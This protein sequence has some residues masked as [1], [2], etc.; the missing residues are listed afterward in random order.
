MMARIA[1][2]LILLVSMLVPAGAVE[3]ILDFVS[4]AT[5]ER[6]GDLA[7]T[8]T[9]SVQAEGNEIRRGITRDFPTTYHRRRDGSQVVIR[10][11]VLSV[12][13]N[14]N[15]EDYALESMSNGVRVRI[16][17]A[18]RILNTGRHEYAIKYVTTRQIGF[19]SDFDELYWNATGNGSNF[20]I[21]RAEAR[22]TLP[23][24]VPFRQSTFYTGPQ[25][26]NGRDASVVEERPG[27]IVFRTTRAL[28]PKNGLTVAVAWQKG[29]VAPPSGE[30]Q[31]RWW[32]TDNLAVPV[33][34]VGLA[35]V[36]FFYYYAWRRV[37]R[38]PPGGT[39]IPLFGPP[40]GMSAAATR[41]VSNLGF[42]QRCFTAAVVDCG[43][44]GH[45]KITGG[46][47][48]PVLAHR[49]G[50]KP[51]PAAEAAMVHKL[52]ARKPSLTLDQVNHETL[53]SAREALSNGLDQAYLG[54][55][56][57]N[58]FGWSGLG[59][60]AVVALIVLVV[61]SLVFSHSDA[62]TGGLIAG[63]AVPLL[64]VLGGASLIYGGLQ[65]NPVS[66][67]RII[68]GALVLGGAA[69]FG[70]FLVKTNGHGWIDLVPAIACYVAAALVGIGFDWL[71]APSVEGRKIMDQIEGFREY[72]G[73]AEEDR[74]NALNPPDKTPE[75]F[76]R[77]LPY[78]IAL[79]VENA[80]AKRFA[81]VLAAAGAAAATTAWYAGSESLSSDPVGF[82]SHLSGD[83]NQTI[84][85]ASTA[86]GSS[87][88]SDGS[89]SGSGGGGSSGGGGGGGGVGGW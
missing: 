71:Q 31:A 60:V 48:K 44:N 57:A 36:L 74:L 35:L 18:N 85:S 42:D 59:F 13:R 73:V 2:A 8:E 3:R 46:G 51:V 17:S 26:A 72:L 84:S 14:G 83:L 4:D 37:G 64:F 63:V 33:A 86:P 68:V 30:Q 24:A 65:R 27:R 1:A 9:I 47:D 79:D 53:S 70:L 49:K 78:A 55:L 82:A 20:T 80:W 39:V 43:V 6:N 32:L 45:L 15:P 5:V 76:E 25:D 54:K 21:D 88:S 22:I 62:G 10:F 81:G 11:Q 41:Y 12:T 52:F 23:E 38:D 61:L 56:F 7:V 87:D 29:V 66:Y 34:L 67:W 89:S 69:A 75:L 50:G 16:G 58:N 19:F 40:A 77:F 28:P